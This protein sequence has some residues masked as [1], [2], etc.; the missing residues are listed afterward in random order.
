MPVVISQHRNPEDAPRENPAFTSLPSKVGIGSR[1]FHKRMTVDPSDD[2]QGSVYSVFY[3]TNAFERT[4][5]EEQDLLAD[6]YGED[7]A[8]VC[9]ELAGKV[10]VYSP[11][12]IY[13]STN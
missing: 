4:L 7:L 3:A 13:N 9:A 2:G 1:I 8:R 10:G 11:S 6:A 12:E 5:D